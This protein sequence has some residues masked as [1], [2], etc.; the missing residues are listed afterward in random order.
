MTTDLTTLAARLFDAL[1]TGDTAT[2]KSLY[3]PDA[4]L[5]S[6]TTQRSIDAREVAAFLPLFVKR[7]PDRTYADRRIT[8]FDGGFIHRHRLTGT[9]RDGARVAVECCAMVFVT[10]GAVTRIEEYLDARQLEAVMG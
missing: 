1:E 7:M 10:D 8:L 9:R 3:A 4:T 2:H 5:W 6:N